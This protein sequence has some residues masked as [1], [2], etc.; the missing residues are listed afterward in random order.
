MPCCARWCQRVRL[1][2]GQR[3]GIMG[4]I[5]SSS[6]RQRLLTLGSDLVDDQRRKLTLHLGPLELS[7]DKG[8]RLQPKLNVGLEGPAFYCV[9]GLRD[10]RG[11]ALVVEALALALLSV[12]SEGDSIASFLANVE[13]TDKLPF[14]DVLI[15]TLPRVLGI[16]L[17]ATGV[18]VEAASYRVDGRI[19]FYLGVGFTAGVYLGCW[20]DTDDYYSVGVEGT[21]AS[22]IGVGFTI[23]VGLHRHGRAVRVTCFAGSAGFD[24]VCRLKAPKRHFDS[25]LMCASEYDGA[26]ADRLTRRRTRSLGPTFKSWF[27]LATESSR[28]AFENVVSGL[29]SARASPSTSATLL[30]QSSPASAAEPAADSAESAESTRP[31]AVAKAAAAAVANTVTAALAAEYAPV[32]AADEAEAASEPADSDETTAAGGALA[33]SP[34]RLL[35]LAHKPSGR[36]VKAMPEEPLVPTS[37]HPPAAAAEAAVPTSLALG[38]PRHGLAGKQAR[39]SLRRL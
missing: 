34:S 20:P 6:S 25:E 37:D 23:R 8:V 26:A 7:F 32:P 30:V 3:M 15:V 39:A 12:Q 19:F 29:I 11:G 13:T 38:R 2:A 9:A 21:I 27:N 36:L 1:V 22:G 10:T 5:D 33:W 31:V 16:V 18:D 17:E 35:S 14:F 4:G 24:V 28:V